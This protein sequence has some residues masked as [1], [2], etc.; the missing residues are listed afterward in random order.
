MP[1]LQ[2][3]PAMPRPEEDVGNLRVALN[4]LPWL[5]SFQAYGFVVFVVAA[6]R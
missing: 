4:A 3:D 1:P 2:R 5:I 6:N